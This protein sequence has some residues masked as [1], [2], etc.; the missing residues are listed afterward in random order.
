MI[1]NEVKHVFAS[2]VTCKMTPTLY[3][4]AKISVEIL[5]KDPFESVGMS[6]GCISPCI[7]SIGMYMIGEKLSAAL[8]E[9]TNAYRRENK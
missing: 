7:L 9:A 5:P 2:A 6:N 1:L 8:K 3:L 4:D